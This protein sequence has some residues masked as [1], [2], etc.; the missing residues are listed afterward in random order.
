M[1]LFNLFRK[2]NTK[3]TNNDILIISENGLKRSY[4]GLKKKTSGISFRI[5]SLEPEIV[6]LLWFADGPL[7]N[8]PN[9][10][11]KKTSEYIGDF[12]FCISLFET[13]EPSLITLSLPIEEPANIN[14]IDRPKY[15]PSYQSFSPE[16][17][18]IYLDWLTNID[19]EINIGYVFVFYYGLERHL[20]FGD[21]ESA[22]SMILR[23]RKI[24]KH[25]TFLHYSSN[26]LIAACIYHK[27]S[28]WFFKFLQSNTSLDELN[29]NAIYI[30]AKRS[31]EIGLTS[32][33]LMKIAGSIGFK[34]RRY[35][36]DESVLF[37]TLL[38]N[39]LMGKYS[40]E[41]LSLIKYDLKDCP[42]VP[43]II[44]ANVS[45]VMNEG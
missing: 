11:Q 32:S 20:F 25:Q 33:E 44:I 27:Q 18:W 5:N 19:R 14:D 2:Q 4:D 39:T 24:H 22:F 16:Q 9:N 36:K 29:I 38:T 41:E 12:E 26:A 42:I 23:L 31:L 3:P 15:Y 8:F 45:V 40:A 13:M 43:Q 21:A 35:I 34:Y 10:H 1:A 28:D 17:R 37:K 7:K 30:L 6:K